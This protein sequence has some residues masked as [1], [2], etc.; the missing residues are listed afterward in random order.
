MFYSSRPFDMSATMNLL[1]RRQCGRRKLEGG[2]QG[3]SDP[4]QNHCRRLGCAIR[5]D[6]LF[7]NL[8]KHASDI[9]RECVYEWEPYDWKARRMGGTFV[10]H[11]A[12]L[13]GAEQIFAVGYGTQKR[14]F[15]AEALWP[16]FDFE[17]IL[18]MQA[19]Q[20]QRMHRVQRKH[21]MQRM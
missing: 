7:N 14:N 11:G 10:W 5:L 9:Q 4:T 2:G 12:C 6:M 21:R 17:S 15:N 18:D 8:G 3:K 1:K 20:V 16:S 13:P 19:F